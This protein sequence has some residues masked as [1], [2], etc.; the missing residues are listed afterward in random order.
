[1][2]IDHLTLGQILKWLL[3]ISD[4]EE[5][6]EEVHSVDLDVVSEGGDVDFLVR[7]NK[8]MIVMGKTII[9]ILRGIKVEG[10][11]NL[12]MML[13]VETIIDV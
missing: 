7:T 13:E 2:S 10:M 1:M 5:R 12:F 9:S 6:V 11:K 4:L 8:I 3:T